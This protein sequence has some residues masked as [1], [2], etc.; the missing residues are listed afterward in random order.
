MKC[1]LCT[2]I[3]WNTFV[4]DQ[5]LRNAC[6]YSLITANICFIIAL[7]KMELGRNTYAAFW[8]VQSASCL[9][10]TM[11][12]IWSFK[13]KKYPFF[14]CVMCCSYSVSWMV[15]RRNLMPYQDFAWF[16]LIL[17]I[18][19]CDTIFKSYTFLCGECKHKNSLIKHE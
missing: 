4:S 7:R 15:T 11:S 18:N 14:Y 19:T 9:S 6:L 2:N 3:P 5:S 8:F 10:P 16:F 12:D 17:A 13:E 1:G